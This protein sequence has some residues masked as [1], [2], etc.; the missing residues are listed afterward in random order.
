MKKKTIFIQTGENPQNIS[1]VQQKKQ[2]TF[3]T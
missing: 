3:H 1:N 2:H